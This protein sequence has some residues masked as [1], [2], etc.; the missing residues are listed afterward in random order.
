[1]WFDRA[2]NGI[3]IT[4]E[5]SSRQKR[6][7]YESRLSGRNSLSL[8]YFPSGSVEVNIVASGYY[9]LEVTIEPNGTISKKMELMPDK[10]RL[11]DRY[12]NE[13][14]L[15][16]SLQGITP[17]YL[18]QIELRPYVCRTVARHSGLPRTVGRPDYHLPTIGFLK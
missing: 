2:V 3:R 13:T 9:L 5:Y 1:M 8:R 15:A 11:I 16:M 4:S 17:I 7:I 18:D 6:V 14:D 12:S 10:F